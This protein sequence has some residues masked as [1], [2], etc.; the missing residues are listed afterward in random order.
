MAELAITLPF[1]LLLV[2]GATDL[3]RLFFAQVTLNGAAHNGGIYASSSPS[4]ATNTTAIRSAALADTTTLVDISPSNP[5]VV[6]STGTDPYGFQTVVVTVTYAFRAVV[7][8]PGLPE[9][10]TMTRSV[11]MRVKP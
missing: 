2:L 8:Y 10:I 11:Q 3:G 1:L 6:S 7:P 5:N 4:A 9:S